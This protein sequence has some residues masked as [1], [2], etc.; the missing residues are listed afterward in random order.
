MNDIL[1]TPP[2]SKSTT[3]PLLLSSAIPSVSNPQP[4][5]LVQDVHHDLFIPAVDMQQTQ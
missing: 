2:T 4:L 1:P 3:R 5:A